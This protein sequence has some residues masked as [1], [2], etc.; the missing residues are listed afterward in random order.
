MK[1]YKIHPAEIKRKGYSLL[2]GLAKTSPLAR[3]LRTSSRALM[4]QQDRTQNALATNVNVFHY[5]GSS[6]QKAGPLH[7]TIW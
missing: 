4:L 1:G 7:L 6:I 3:T 2:L 5:T